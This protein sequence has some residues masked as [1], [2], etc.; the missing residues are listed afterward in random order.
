MRAQFELQ[1]DEMRGPVDDCRGCVERGAL[2]ADEVPLLR[3]Y[4]PLYGLYAWAVKKEAAARLL[5]EAFP[6]GGQVDHALSLWLVQQSL[7]Q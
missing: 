1:I 3:M 2:P 5:H 6:V 7:V 4:S